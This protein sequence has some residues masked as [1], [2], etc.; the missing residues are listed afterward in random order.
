MQIVANSSVCGVM[1]SRAV[2][3]VKPRRLFLSMCA[4]AY[5]ESST[6]D[7]RAC[8]GAC[9]CMRTG[10]R[11]PRCRLARTHAAGEYRDILAREY[12][13]LVDKISINDVTANIA[14]PSENLVG[15][16]FSEARQRSFVLV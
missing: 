14:S 4:S 13:T 12:I 6:A 11:Q 3:I 15:G 7:A 8:A 2:A 1:T 9:A 5:I 10:G 16:K